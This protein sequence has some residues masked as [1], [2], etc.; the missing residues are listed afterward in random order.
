[1]SSKNKE[2]LQTKAPENY[3][4]RSASMPGIDTESFL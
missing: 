4:T 1:M 2:I 3:R